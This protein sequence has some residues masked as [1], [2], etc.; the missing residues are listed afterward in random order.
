MGF[1]LLKVLKDI[2][3]A[4]YGGCGFQ[5]EVDIP[6]GTNYVPFPSDLFLYLY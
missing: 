1:F 6:I 5:K 2:L 3:F 4:L